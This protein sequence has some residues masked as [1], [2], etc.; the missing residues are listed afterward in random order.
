[1]NHHPQLDAL[2]AHLAAQA[3]RLTEADAPLALAVLHEYLDQ[4]AALDRALR[5]DVAQF[6]P[7]DEI[8]RLLCWLFVVT[9]DA[10]THSGREG[11]LAAHA[12]SGQPLA[13]EAADLHRRLTDPA[14]L[15]A[16]GAR[17]VVTNRADGRGCPTP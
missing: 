7:A 10:A 8:G 14:F 16:R 3:G 5:A 6:R 9:I 2:R 15:A 12:A 4:G 13:A 11:A 17:P 1:M